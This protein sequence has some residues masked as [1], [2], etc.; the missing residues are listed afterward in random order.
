MT[1]PLCPRPIEPLLDLPERELATDA[2]RCIVKTDAEI[3]VEAEYLAVYSD[4]ALSVPVEMH[5]LVGGLHVAG[6]LSFV[7]KAR[8]FVG[9]FC[10]GEEDGLLRLVA[11]CR[12]T[13]YLQRQPPY[14]LLSS[15]HAFS[16]LFVGRFLV[17][18]N[19]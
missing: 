10:V 13:K 5:R 12:R 4:P 14:M 19:S 9:L 11:D 7:L 3:N 15:G 1:R 2:W 16:S 17:D 8:S 18:R 6:L